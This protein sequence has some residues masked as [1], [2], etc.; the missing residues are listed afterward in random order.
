MKLA[1][2]GGTP[3]EA[4]QKDNFY[5]PHIKA[6]W[7]SLYYSLLDEYLLSMNSKKS[8]RLCEKS[9]ITL[10]HITAFSKTTLAV[11]FHEVKKFI[12]EAEANYRRN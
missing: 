10:K 12:K 3:A 9:C 1:L 4:E 11:G 2:W 5:K 7:E 6:F 8:K